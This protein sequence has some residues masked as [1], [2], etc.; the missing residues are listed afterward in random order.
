MEALSPSLAQALSTLRRTG[1]SLVAVNGTE[2]TLCHERGVKDLYRLLKEQPATLRGASVADK[3]VGKGAAALMALGGVREVYALVASRP[4][5]ALLRQEGVAA[6]ALEVAENIINRAGTDICP[7]ERLCADA[8]CAADCLPL[9][10][11]FL[12]NI[13]N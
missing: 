12:N 3:V 10:E 8:A 7:V 1:C 13:K 4:A 6:M 5:L 9:I 11:E 2:V